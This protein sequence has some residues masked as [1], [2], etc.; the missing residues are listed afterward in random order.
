VSAAVLSL[1]LFPTIAGQLL[2]QRPNRFER[3]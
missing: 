1:L 3:E 2:R